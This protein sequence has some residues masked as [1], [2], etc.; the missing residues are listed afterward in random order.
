MSKYDYSLNKKCLD[1]GKLIQNHSI[2]CRKCYSQNLKG[3]FRTP[4]GYIQVYNPEHPFCNNRGYVR[5]HRLVMEAHLKR[6]L[7]PKEIVHHINGIRDDNR[8]E[9]LELMSKGEHSS[10]HKTGSKHHYWKG[11]LSRTKE[12]RRKWRKNN[13]EKIKAQ[14]KKRSKK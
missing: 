7:T 8:I 10:Y 4:E 2:R 12:Y 11:G 14:Y 3:K 5:E 9:N 6:Y 13:P 1:C